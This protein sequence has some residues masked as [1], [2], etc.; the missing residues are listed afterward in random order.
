MTKSYFNDTSTSP[1]KFFF[2]KIFIKLFLLLPFLLTNTTLLAQIGIKDMVNPPEKDTS[3]TKI[4]VSEGTIVK[5]L[6]ENLNPKVEIVHAKPKQKEKQKF[7]TSKPIDRT[8]NK[9]DEAKNPDSKKSKL[10]ISPSPAS[11]NAISL[12]Q[13]HEIAAISTTANFP[14]KQLGFGFLFTEKNPE[15]FFKT[16]EKNHLLY[17]NISNF[18]RL[19]YNNIRPPP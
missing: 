8:V 15:Y 9:P 2:Q 16:K 18:Y 17:L 13:I 6:S 5:N 10:K 1:A 7:A 14:K 3:P 12:L 11:K 4:Y 19:S